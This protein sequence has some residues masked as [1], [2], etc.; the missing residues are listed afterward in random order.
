MARVR[1]L[2]RVRA[3]GS[4]TGI[5]PPVADFTGTPLSG[6]SPLDVDFTST[7]TDADNYFWEKSDDGGMTWVEFDG[8]PT[9]ENPS[10]TFT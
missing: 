4:G 6:S 8:T 3:G 9:A 1:Y 10:E 2:H 5:T 7:S